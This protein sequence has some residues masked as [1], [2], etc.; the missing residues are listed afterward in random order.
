MSEQENP[1]VASASPEQVEEYLRKRE[2]IEANY[3][4]LLDAHKNEAA[5][6]KLM[7]DM[8]EDELRNKISI[9]KLAELEARIKQG[10]SERKLKDQ[11]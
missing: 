5:Y 3:K 1:D 2:K 10:N 7:A 4:I 11:A 8:A 6:V 9:M